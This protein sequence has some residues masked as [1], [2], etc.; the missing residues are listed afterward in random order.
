MTE[1][2]FVVSEQKQTL[3]AFQVE[4]LLPFS[5]LYHRKFISL[6]VDSEKFKV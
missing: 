3:S 6:Q 1:P 2:G 5:V 4:T